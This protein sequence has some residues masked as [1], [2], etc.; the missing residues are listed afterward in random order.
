VQCVHAPLDVGAMSLTCQYGTI[1]KIIDYGSNNVQK[2]DMIDMCLNTD[3]TK[4][5]KPNAVGEKFAK[6][7]G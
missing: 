1:G 3:A 7:L 2:T 5:C 6:F 4:G